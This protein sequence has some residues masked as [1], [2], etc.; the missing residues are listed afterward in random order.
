MTALESIRIT[1]LDPTD[2]AAVER[3]AALLVESFAE[4]HPRAWPDVESARAEVAECLDPEK[5]TLG[6]FDADGRLIGW[7]GAQ[8]AYY[9]DVWELHPMVVDERVRG[10][11]I[12][13][14]LAGALEDAV[15]AR[16][17]IT[18][19]LGTD[20]ENAQTSLGG[21]EIFPD[22]LDR[23]REIR[24]VNGHPFVIYQ[25]LGYELVGILP[26]ANGFGRHDI[27]M[28]KRL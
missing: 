14:R 23:L 13:R 21:A 3:A 16:G 6:A 15:R 1:P 2:A 24:D 10:R 25:R 27:Y 5:I 12:G 9:G 8:A 19:W 18:L 20:D 22:V 17:A 28:A 26:H 11:G 7:I 4:H